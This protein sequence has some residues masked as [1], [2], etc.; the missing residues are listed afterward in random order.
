[1]VAVT[2]FDQEVGPIPPEVN[3]GRTLHLSR[4]FVQHSATQSQRS[5]VLMPSYA[6]LDRYVRS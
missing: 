2:F 4:L 1:M 3:S 5:L 6:F